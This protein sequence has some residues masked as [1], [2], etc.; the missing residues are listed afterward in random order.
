MRRWVR[1]SDSGREPFGYAFL[2]MSAFDLDWNVA[3]MEGNLRLADQVLEAVSCGVR[4]GSWMPMAKT[5]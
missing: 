1:D 5:W 2:K 4:L 3:D